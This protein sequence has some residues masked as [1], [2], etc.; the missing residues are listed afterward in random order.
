LRRVGRKLVPAGVKLAS[1]VHLTEGCHKAPGGL[2]RSR[3]LECDGTVVDLEL[4]G[5]VDCRP[6]AGLSALA[7]GLLGARLDDPRLGER[8]ASLMQR[9][10]VAAPGMSADDVAAAIAASRHRGPRQH[11][12]GAM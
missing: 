7:R 10:G 6:A 8:I 11:T 4:S 5:D 9:L 3:L 1:G 12:G 2:L